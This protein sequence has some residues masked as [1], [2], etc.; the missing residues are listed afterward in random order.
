MSTIDYHK[1]LV[2]LRYLRR[3][4]SAVKASPSPYRVKAIRLEEL[5]RQ[6]NTLVKWI[7]MEKAMSAHNNSV[8]CADTLC[9]KL[10]VLPQ[11]RIVVGRY[12]YCK[13]CAAKKK[14]D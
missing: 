11:D 4:G 12:V 10:I 1:I 7:R 8:I 14:G 9:R 13:E 2:K 5:T 6:M 3:C